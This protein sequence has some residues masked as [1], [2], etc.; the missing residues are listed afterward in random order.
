MKQNREEVLDLLEIYES[1]LTKRQQG[2]M[3]SYFRYDL[4]LAEIAEMEKMSRSGALDAIHQSIK[5]LQ[6]YENRLGII[7][8]RKALKDNYSK[9]EAGDEKAQAK[10]KEMIEHGI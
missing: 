4:S 1:L 2:I 9:A 5:K 6:E 3:D 7:K 8:F 10:L